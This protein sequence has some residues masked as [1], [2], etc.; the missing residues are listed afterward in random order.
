MSSSAWQMMYATNAIYLT[1]DNYIK[2]IYEND[3]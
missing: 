1:S 3:I 2:D